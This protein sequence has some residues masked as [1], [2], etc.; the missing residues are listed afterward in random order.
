MIEVT[1]LRKELGMYLEESR[2]PSP[3]YSE[4]PSWLSTTATTSEAKTPK[5][6]TTSYM[7]LM[8]L[9]PNTM[10]ERNKVTNCA[11]ARDGADGDSVRQSSRS[12]E[13]AS[14]SFSARTVADD[15]SDGESEA[16]SVE[17]E[18]T[19]KEAL[20]GQVEDWKDSDLEDD[21]EE[22]VEV[23]SSNYDDDDFDE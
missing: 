14:V 5:S 23:P 16:S 17:I 12:E 20:R 4:T 15:D 18:S 6:W 8:G 21:S 2:S 9:K 7:K 1:R 11:S 22:S 10:P 13:P 3:S 19:I